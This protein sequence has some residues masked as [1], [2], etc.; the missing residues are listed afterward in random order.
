[1][2]LL[3]CMMLLMMVLSSS[4]LCP[5]STSLYSLPI[6]WQL[7]LHHQHINTSIFLLFN[8]FFLSY[9]LKLCAVESFARLLVL[10]FDCW[11]VEP[12]GVGVS[13]MSMLVSVDC[14][15]SVVICSS[16]RSF[17]FALILS[18]LDHGLAFCYIILALLWFFFEI[19]LL[20]NAS[21]L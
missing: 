16:T 10:L 11:V 8:V 14:S 3:H 13:S 17:I 20:F 6:S 21:Y 9:T 15:V 19:I 1:M 7:W 4:S 2:A 5:P 18:P 12:V